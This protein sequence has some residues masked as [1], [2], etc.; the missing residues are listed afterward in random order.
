M[1]I[2][3]SIICL[4]KKKKQSQNNVTVFWLLLN[5]SIPVL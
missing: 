2:I 3:D 1:G 4:F 5:D